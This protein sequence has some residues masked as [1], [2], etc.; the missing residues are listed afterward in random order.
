[1][2]HR[3]EHFGEGVL[4][5][6]ARAGHHRRGQR[7]DLQRAFP[8]GL[9]G[10]RQAVAGPDARQAVAFGEQRDGRERHRTH[11][12]RRT[13][14]EVHARRCGHYILEPRQG[15]HKYKDDRPGF[16]RDKHRHR[17]RGARL[18]AHDKHDI[19]GIRE[20]NETTKRPAAGKVPAAGAVI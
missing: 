14:D 9:V 15:E 11:S 2:G 19:F 3:F 10:A 8:V 6:H 18:R 4:L 16:E 17:R 7:P 12:G 5:V 13:L 1:M 20:I